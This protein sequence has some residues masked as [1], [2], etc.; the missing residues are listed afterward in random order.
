MAIDHFLGRLYP[1]MTMPVADLSGKLAIVTGAN[2]G[3]GLETA[4]ALAGMRAHVVLACRDQVRGEEA[5]KQIIE[6]T[7]NLNVEVEMLDCGKFASVRAFLRRWEEREL[8]QVDLLINNAGGLTSTVALTEDGYEQTY[9][10][11]HLSHVMLTHGLL[12]AGSISSN[13]RIVS[14]SSIGFYMSHSLDKNNAGNGDILAKFGNE[15]GAKLSLNEMMQLYYRSKASQAVWTM[16]L[17]R[18]LSAIDGW[19]GIT[20]QACH[21]GTTSTPIW[22]QPRG[23]GSLTDVASTLFKLSGSE[24]GI[25][26]KQGAVTVVWVAVSPEPTSTGMEGRFWDRMRWKWVKPWSLDVQLQNDLWDTWCSDAEA[27]LR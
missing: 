10:S 3:I 19:K 18:R 13:G 4:R 5:K 22:Y 1:E 11:N 12:N 14:V 25:S 9:Q 26:S 21:P 16:A 27:P 2:S 17:Q 20:V 15:I 7:G 8:K 23:A 24:L 6:S